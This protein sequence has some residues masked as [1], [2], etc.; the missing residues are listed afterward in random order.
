MVSAEKIDRAI[1][2]SIKIHPD[3][4]LQL[5]TTIYGNANP[6]NGVNISNFTK[7]DGA[8]NSIKDATTKDFINYVCHEVV[9]IYNTGVYYYNKNEAGRAN[10]DKN[11]PGFSSIVEIYD[12]ISSNQVISTYYLATHKKELAVIC[13]L[14]SRYYRYENNELN[15]AMLNL[16]EKF[17]RI[18]TDSN[19]INIFDKLDADRVLIDNCENLKVHYGTVNK[20]KKHFVENQEAVLHLTRNYALDNKTFATID[21]GDAIEQQDSV[22]ILEHP[23]NEKFKLMAVADGMGGTEKGAEIGKEI[24]Q[25]LTS[26]FETRITEVFYHPDALEN[27]LKIK[28]ESIS[29]AIYQKYNSERIKG[30]ASLTVAIVADDS[31]IVSSVGNS[32]CFINRN[33][34][35]SLLSKDDTV[36]WALEAAKGEVDPNKLAFHPQAKTLTKFVGVYNLK[37]VET[38]IIKNIAYK[39]LILM[40]NGGNGLSVDNIHFICENT[41]DDEISKLL[42]S[43]RYTKQYRVNA[44]NEDYNNI[45]RADDNNSTVVVHRGGMK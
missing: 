42:V 7:K 9:K 25:E 16:I 10:F 27:M 5:F 37:D 21:K 6:V 39:H 12:M 43:A 18:S 11:F 45:Y 35:T 28:I 36:A 8:R 13:N 19:P 20:C 44:I 14:I 3:Y 34:Y 23:K 15:E 17:G 30:G 29:D 24:I 41:P 33:D 40:T 38:H 4:L 1:I 2:T 32:R 31:T 26:W 22:I